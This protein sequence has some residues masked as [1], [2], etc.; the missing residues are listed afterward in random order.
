MRTDL[1]VASLVLLLGAGCLGGTPEDQV[2]GSEGP[3][4]TSPLEELPANARV[5]YPCPPGETI[6]PTEEVCA[7]IVR[8]DA[9]SLA[10]PQIAVHP[11]DPETIAIAVSQTPHE[12]SEEETSPGTGQR[13]PAVLAT[14]DGGRS[15][16]HHTVPLGDIPGLAPAEPRTGADPSPV[17]DAD[18]R[19]HLTGL[20]VTNQ[21]D[22]QV[23]HASSS[24]LGARWEKPNLLAHDGDND[25]QW[26]SRL[27]DDTLFTTW[28]NQVNGTGGIATSNDAGESW[29]RQGNASVL[30]P[31]D[32]ISPVVDTRIGALVGCEVDEGGELVVHRLDRATGD[33][34]RLA[35]IPAGCSSN[36]PFLANPVGEVLVSSCYTGTMTASG[37]GGASWNISTNVID[38]ASVDDDWPSG[39]GPFVFAMDAGAEGF[40]HVLFTY[41]PS[42]EDYVGFDRGQRPVA[43]VVL[44]PA[45]LSIVHETELKPPEASDRGPSPTP[46]SWDDYYDIAVVEDRTLLVWTT[47]EWAM[48][49]TFA[50]TSTDP[51]G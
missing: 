14:T 6:Q 10:E 9:R 43:H 40:V 38:A 24:D 18:G 45:D 29:V 33:A 30:D 48:A 2:G 20:I 42:A 8:E 25:R 35:T 49:Y 44:H 1:L 5:I 19:L 17:I 26:T 16:Q 28:R 31:C 13:G 21:S 11:G 34:A 22:S 41:V 39:A 4:D 51:A 3:K 50:E 32:T 27:L 12:P 37:D 47:N 46:G 7:G 15:W 36:S 23:F